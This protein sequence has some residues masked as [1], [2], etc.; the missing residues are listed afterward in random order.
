MLLPN[1]RTERNKN[2]ELQRICFTG[3]FIIDT[4]AVCDRDVYKKQQYKK[5][6]YTLHFRRDRNTSDIFLSYIKGFS[7]KRFGYIH[8]DFRKH[9]AGNPLGR[10]KRIC[11]QSIQAV[12][13]EKRG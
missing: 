5:L 12:Q 8:S 13:S 4:R 7:A 2:N 3:T 6:A 11:Q 10:D 9:N 1:S